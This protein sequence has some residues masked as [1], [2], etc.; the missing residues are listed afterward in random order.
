ML[1]AQGQSSL[2]H[3]QVLMSVN[4][5]PSRRHSLLAKSEPIVQHSRKVLSKY[6]EEDPDAAPDS[7][8]EAST[9][10]LSGSAAASLDD[11]A[12]NSPVRQVFG[13]TIEAGNCDSPY[14]MDR[15]AALSPEKMLS[16]SAFPTNG[17][18]NVSS[19]VVAAAPA[20]SS[21]AAAPESQSLEGARA[22]LVRRK[23]RN[24][25]QKLKR[26]F[27]KSE[28]PTAVTAVDEVDLAEDELSRAV[29]S[30]RRDVAAAEERV[31]Q[32]ERTAL[33]TLRSEKERLELRLRLLL[34]D[35]ETRHEASDSLARAAAPAR[36]L[37]R[38]ATQAP[39]IARSARLERA[40]LRSWTALPGPA[41]RLMCPG[42]KVRSFFA[43]QVL[44]RTKVSAVFTF[45]YT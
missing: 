24:V 1:L 14:F 40:L 13:T 9:C 28:Q 12:K 20:P 37:R 41:I 8:A 25:L 18:E 11:E 26:G 35:E 4:A 2:Q 31:A 3:M 45:Y 33:A 7:S 29:E 39:A 36:V 22:T 19:S 34:R 30:L 16:P 43:A 23:S 5:S 21:S 44:K 10:S 6:F 17:K 42:Q 15:S 27:R 32:A 38:P